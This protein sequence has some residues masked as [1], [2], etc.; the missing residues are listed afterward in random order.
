MPG[1]QGL[2]LHRRADRVSLHR[3]FSWQVQAFGGMPALRDRQVLL[4]RRHNHL[5]RLLQRDRQCER[6]QRLL[7]LPAGHVR[8]D[9]HG[10]L[11]GLP[12]PHVSGLPV[13]R[14][15]IGMQALPARH[16]ELDVRDAQPGHV[17][18]VPTRDI[19]A[20]PELSGLYS[21]LFLRVTSH[22]LPCLST[23]ALLWRWGRQLHA[24]SG[25]VLFRQE[26][27]QQL[28]HLSARDLLATRK[29][30]LPAVP[31]RRVLRQPQRNRLPILPSR[32][33]LGSNWR[34]K[35]HRMRAGHVLHWECQRLPILPVRNFAQHDQPVGV[36][37]MQERDLRAAWISRGIPIRSCYG[38][39]SSKP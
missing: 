32:I 16:V 20:Q 23:R 39:D 29:L 5:Q 21:W 19:R 12:V 35:L 22:N 13:R 9:R 38:L 7:D 6:G 11:P 14:L 24:V 15:C 1:R 3:L 2:A 28:S 31:D 18:P 33:I 17:L 26:Q 34:H 30:D 36:P 25:G 8:S 10:G 4:H 27:H 37:A